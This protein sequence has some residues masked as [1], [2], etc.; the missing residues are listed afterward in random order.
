MKQLCFE[1]FSMPRGNAAVKKKQESRVIAIR[2][3]MVLKQ[4]A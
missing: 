2:R 3:Q 4:Y 1:F